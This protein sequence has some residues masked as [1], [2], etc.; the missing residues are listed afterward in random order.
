MKSLEAAAALGGCAKSWVWRRPEGA[1]QGV[2]CGGTPGRPRA[3]RERCLRE[4]DKRRL[5]S[6]HVAADTGRLQ[7]A[8]VREV[9]G[10]RGG[11]FAAVNTGS[12]HHAA[13]GAEFVGDAE[14]VPSLALA[15][16]WCCRLLSLRS[17]GLLRDSGHGL[18]GLG[19]AAAL[20]WSSSPSGAAS[21]IVRAA[22]C[23][24]FGSPHRRHR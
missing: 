17:G 23:G 13:F 21:P 6:M 7:W 22:R 9:R 18:L 4:G 14:R 15:P 19:E 11:D 12:G 20:M 16:G 1:V 2:R 10:G 5:P 3:D 8:P 24:R